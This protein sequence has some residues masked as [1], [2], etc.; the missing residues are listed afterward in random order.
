VS[1]VELGD[2]DKIPSNSYEKYAMVD[3]GGLS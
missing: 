3:N 1:F 2:L